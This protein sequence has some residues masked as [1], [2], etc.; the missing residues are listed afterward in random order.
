MKSCPNE[1]FVALALAQTLGDEAV[2]AKLICKE[3]V[4][5]DSSWPSRNVY[6]LVTKGDCASWYIQSSPGRYISFTLNDFTL[7]YADTLLL[8]F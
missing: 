8:H 1:T 5:T 7:L 6:D 2:K 4:T 3:N